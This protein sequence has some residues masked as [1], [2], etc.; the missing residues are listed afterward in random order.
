MRM[1]DALTGG[2]LKLIDA[3]RA[4]VDHPHGLS[5]R[6]LD[7]LFA[8]DKPVTLAFH[9]DPWPIHRLA[10]AGAQLVRGR[11]HLKMELQM[12]GGDGGP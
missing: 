8:T 1:A 12:S 9:G 6:D 11:H 10:V 4:A 2:E 7:V 3:S 5:D